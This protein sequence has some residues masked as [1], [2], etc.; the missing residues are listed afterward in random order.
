MEVL[1]LFG[2]CPPLPPKPTSIIEEIMEREDRIV[3]GLL[4]RAAGPYAGTNAE[5]ALRLFTDQPPFE[6]QWIGAVYR[7]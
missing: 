5:T 3:Y 7:E 1:W 6:Q 2:I 4:E